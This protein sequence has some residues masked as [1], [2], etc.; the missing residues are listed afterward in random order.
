MTD[1]RNPLSDAAMTPI[2]RHQVRRV[3]DDLIAIRP[4]NWD[5][6]RD[7]AQS[8]AWQAAERLQ[9]QMSKPD[10]R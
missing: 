2:E 3:L 6:P 4:T 8:L 1:H 10:G 5:D 9:A 7:P